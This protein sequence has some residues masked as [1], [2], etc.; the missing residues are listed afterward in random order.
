MPL[1]GA[2]VRFPASAWGDI[3]LFF[4]PLANT[5]AGVTVSGLHKKGNSK[6]SIPK[7]QKS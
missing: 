7:N 4:N 6:S 5:S 3:F 2:G 1:N